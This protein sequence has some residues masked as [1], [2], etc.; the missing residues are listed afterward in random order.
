MQKQTFENKFATKPN[1][2]KDRANPLANMIMAGVL[3]ITLLLVLTYIPLRLHDSLSLIFTFL[4][5][6]FLIASIIFI[7]RN[8]LSLF[9]KQKY[10]TLVLKRIFSHSVFPEVKKQWMKSGQQPISTY[11]LNFYFLEDFIIVEDHDFSLWV[12][13]NKDF[14]YKTLDDE[15]RGRTYNFEWQDILGNKAD[16]LLEDYYISKELKAKL[17]ALHY[18]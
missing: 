13:K 15:Y 6:A 10:R 8:S 9:Q 17:T 14:S 2:F 5:V 7:L 18:S 3:S 4:I 1:F 11:Y 16:H 12:I